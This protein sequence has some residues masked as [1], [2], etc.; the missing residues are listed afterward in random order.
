MSSYRLQL[1]LVGHNRE[2]P[3]YGIPSFYEILYLCLHIFIISVDYGYD[4]VTLH[5]YLNMDI[6]VVD[7]THQICILA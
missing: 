7:T 2:I 4:V 1:D 5:K 6:L 3:L